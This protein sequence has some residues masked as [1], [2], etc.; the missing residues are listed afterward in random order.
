MDAPRPPIY[1]DNQA[2]T[3]LDPRVLAAMMPALTTDFGNA[4]SR[5]H[6][7]GLRARN[8]VD[9][10]RA[11]VAALVCADPVEIVFTSGATESN[12]LAIRGA[13]A[14]RR[15]RGRHLVT[16]TTE[17]K[18]VLDV[19]KEMAREGW[20]VTFLSVDREGRIDLDR[21]RAAIRPD[22]ALVSLMAA[23][24]EIGTLHPIAEIGALAR[25]RGVTFHCDAVQAAGR[26]AID[27]EAWHVDLLSLSAHKLY[28]PKGVGALYVRRRRPR[29]RLVPQIVGGGQEDGLRGGTLN[30]P[31]IVGFGEAA[32]LAR[33][34]LA[35]E[36]AHARALRDRLW[37]G[38]RRAVPE[39]ALNGPA[40]LADRL[41]NNLNVAFACCEAQSILMDLA[42]D[43][44]ASPG[45]ACTSDNTEPS[46]VLLACGL[47]REE[48]IGSIRFSVGRFNTEAEIDAVPA[49]VA[50]SAAR[51]RA[52]SPLWT[53]T[54]A[55]T[56]P[57]ATS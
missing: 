18:A 11:E 3:P 49:R 19:M 22:T 43:V 42:D 25:E 14:A 13:A 27:V 21:L 26:L 50:A 38:L 56:A 46:F 41:P 54:H 53:A 34:G 17:H 31:A 47:T 7:H 4:S 16:A 57:A 37:D 44:A 55:A 12:N 40:D 36:A 20:E 30:V 6:A 8:M 33:E 35:D 51:L 23:N 5:F 1:L 29:A 28:G 52:M 48:A 24:N 2:T 39:V 15:D 9:A 32:R 45:S 10:A